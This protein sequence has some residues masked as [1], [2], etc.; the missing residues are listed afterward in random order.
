M[1]VAHAGHPRVASPEQ[2]LSVGQPGDQF[3]RRVI[4]GG[5]HLSPR[6]TTSE[7]LGRCAVARAW[8]GDRRA[9]SY[10]LSFVSPGRSK[11]LA[12]AA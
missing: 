6:T 5:S 7:Y 3:P 9:S 2:S 12:P 1:P 4:N 10:P 8:A 11:R